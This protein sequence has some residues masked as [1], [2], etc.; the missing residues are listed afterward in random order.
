MLQRPSSWAR[1]DGVLAI[2]K[3]KFVPGERLVKKD[4]LSFVLSPSSSGFGLATEAEQP[5]GGGDERHRILVV[6]FEVDEIFRIGD[7]QAS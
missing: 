7:A 4:S 2:L 3:P 1:D 5:G 6:E